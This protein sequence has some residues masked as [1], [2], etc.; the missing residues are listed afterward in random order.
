[1]PNYVV[2]R[3]GDSDPD[4]MWVYAVDEW[5]AREQIASTLQ[6]DAHNSKAYECREEQ[7]FKVPLD[8]ILHESGE[9]TEVALPLMLRSN[10]N[11]GGCGPQTSDD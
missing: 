9:W 3:N 6:V 5:D 2:R 8:M 7:D 4:R 1:M 10:A 11:D